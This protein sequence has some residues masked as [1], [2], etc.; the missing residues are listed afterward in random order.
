MKAINN[1]FKNFNLFIKSELLRIGFRDT[2]R[3]FF[4]TDPLH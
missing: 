2:V 4:V 1:G 3:K